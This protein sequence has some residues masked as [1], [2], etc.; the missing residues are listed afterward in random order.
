MMTPKGALV[1]A[2]LADAPL[3]ELGA[4]R[5]HPL[6]VPS[7]GSDELCSWR[8]DLPSGG[9]SGRHSV[10]RE[11]I[12]I[13]GSGSVTAKVN[14]TSTTAGPGDALILPVNT[15]LELL[16][17]TAHPPDAIVISPVGFTASAGGHTVAP[18]WSL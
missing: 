5:I 13:V 6:A 1:L 10:D 9:A 17:E 8:V 11:Q 12:I 3:F 4:L 16:N 15:I 2:T 14:G 7:R 18:P